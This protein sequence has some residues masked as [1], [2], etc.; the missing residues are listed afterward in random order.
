MLRHNKQKRN[1]NQWEKKQKKT[2][3]HKGK[4]KG[5]L[6]LTSLI[7]FLFNYA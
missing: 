7:N 5:I 6:K 2:Y 4:S 1:E 3:V